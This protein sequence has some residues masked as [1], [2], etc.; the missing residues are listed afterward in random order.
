MISDGAH[1]C[2]AGLAYR[3]M[4]PF[5]LQCHS[6]GVKQP[7]NLF[8]ILRFAQD[9]SRGKAQDDSRRKAQ[10]DK[11]RNLPAILAEGIKCVYL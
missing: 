2:F 1:R 11:K 3:G 8:K 9:D 4:S 5:I 10:D 7:K 6:E